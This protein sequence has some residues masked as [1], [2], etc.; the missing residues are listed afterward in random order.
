MRFPDGTAVTIGKSETLITL[1]CGA[2]VPGAPHD[3]DDYRATA[4]RL[5]YGE[6][7]LAMCLDHDPLH[8]MLCDWLGVTSHALRQAVGLPHDELLALLEENAVIAV[9][10]LMRRAG[11]QLPR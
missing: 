8:A 7:T 10:Q 3:A 2:T 11:G 5:G 4:E 6:D 1:P 9:Q